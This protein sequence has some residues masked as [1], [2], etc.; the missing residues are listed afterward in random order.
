MRSTWKNLQENLPVRTNGGDKS[1]HKREREV[2]S[3]WIHTASVVQMVRL[4]MKPD[5][6]QSD[7]NG[8]SSVARHG[9]AAAPVRSKFRL[10]G[11]AGLVSWWLTS[12]KPEACQISVT[13]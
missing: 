2:K 12:F 11:G 13:G 6:C 8:Q 1:N 5:I 10:L 7:R 4:A 3:C 9:S